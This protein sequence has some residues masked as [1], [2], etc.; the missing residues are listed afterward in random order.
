[1]HHISMQW[2]T[3]YDFHTVVTVSILPVW[4][5]KEIGAN[6][7]YKQKKGELESQAENQ[8]GRICRVETET[9]AVL[10]FTDAD[11]WE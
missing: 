6:Q 7:V 2:T 3:K 10:A 4:A 5:F 9:P 8:G 11:W 1:M